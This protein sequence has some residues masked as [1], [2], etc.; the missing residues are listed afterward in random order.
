MSTIIVQA[1]VSGIVTGCI[2]ALVALSLVIIF[3]T[4]DV[5]NF[6]GGEFVM[7][8]SFLALFAL[9]YLGVGY[10]LALLL[11]AVAMF[12]LGVIFDAVTMNR[13]GGRLYT[14]Q[15]E[16]VPTIVATIG[17]SYLLKGIVR[18]VP[19]TEE[20]RRIPPLF[21]APPIFVGDVVIQMQDVVIVVATTL[22]MVGLWAFFR[23]TMAGRALRAISQNARAACLSG[24]PVRTLRMV[25]WGLSAGIAAVAGVLFAPKLLITPD[26]GTLVM[27]AFAA[28]IVGGFTSLPGCVVGGIVLGVTQNLVGVLIAPQAI[29]VTPFFII[30]VVLLLRPQGLFG[31]AIALKKV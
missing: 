19:Y 10:A 18:V 20:P 31:D 14:R 22:I 30:M 4:T 25:V 16:L 13:I 24:M 17:L 23:F 29:S 5:V 12:A 11:A 21:N 7:V 9:V 8:G 15:T 2:Y 3:K 27:F 26:S 28:A 6:G 1:V